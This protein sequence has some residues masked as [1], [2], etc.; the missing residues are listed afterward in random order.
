MNQL[1][2]VKGLKY[3]V[4]DLNLMF[5]HFIETFGEIQIQTVVQKK[6]GQ[7]NSNVDLDNLE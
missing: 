2:I 6:Y 5:E 1:E 4:K 3:V 7:M